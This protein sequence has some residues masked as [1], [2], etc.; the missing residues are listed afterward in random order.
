[1]CSVWAADKKYALHTSVYKRYSHLLV[2]VS[3]DMLSLEESFYFFFLLMLQYYM[4]K[5]K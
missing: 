2:P 1:M 5:L 4:I 3:K